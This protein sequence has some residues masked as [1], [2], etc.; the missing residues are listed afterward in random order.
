M[1]NCGASGCHLQNRIE[2]TRKAFHREIL[3]GY[4][5]GFARMNLPVRR[6]IRQPPHGRRGGTDIAAPDQDPCPVPTPL[7][8]PA[9]V[10]SDHRCALRKSFEAGHAESFVPEA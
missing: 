2:L 6:I 3:F 7:G 10:V 9:D 4:S 1:T 8:N 5:P